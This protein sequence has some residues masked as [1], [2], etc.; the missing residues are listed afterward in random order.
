MGDEQGRNFGSDYHDAFE[1]RLFQERTRYEHEELKKFKAISDKAGHGIAMRNL[2]GKFV[3]VN[4][5]YARMHGYTVKEM[6]GKGLSLI[7][8]AEQIK[9]VRELREQ[10]AGN[11][12]A[13]I[14]HRRKDGSFFPALVNGSTITDEDGVPLYYAAT[15]VDITE[16]KRKEVEL[17]R[18]KHRIE[19]I[20]QT[21]MNGFCII[22]MDGK[23]LEANLAACQITGHNRD[24]LIG[25]QIRGFEV[26]GDKEEVTEHAKR[27]MK[28]GSHRFEVRHKHK[29]GHVLDLEFSTNYV[30]MGNESF[31]FVFFRDTTEMKRT[32]QSLKEKQEELERKN[33]ELEQMNS[34]LKVLFRKREEDKLEVEQNF[35]T[36][37]RDLVMPNIERLK[38]I[39]TDRKQI[40]YLNILEGNLRNIISPFTR[41]LNAQFVSL[42]PTEIQVANL[43]KEGKTSKE[44]AKLMN[45]SPRTVEF[46]RDRIRKKVGIKNEK[47]NLRSFLLSMQ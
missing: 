41:R 6:L 1:M 46:H 30:K 44:I 11:Y 24:E 5:A 2:D 28:K 13:E 19:M 31:F 36:N 3:Y 16:L 21:T 22:D 17:R 7:H 42:S 14:E 25:A 40:A 34:A 10:H 37:V 12:V 33:F 9:R 27:A 38:K 23:V 8:N 43:V 26:E 47:A 20:L 32:A 35:L 18:E 15:V 29:D 4:E 39:S 45:L